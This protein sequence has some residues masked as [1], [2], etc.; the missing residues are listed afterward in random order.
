M[1]GHWRYTYVSTLFASSVFLSCS[2]FWGQFPGLSLHERGENAP[3]LFLTLEKERVGISFTFPLSPFPGFYFYF[4]VSLSFHNNVTSLTLTPYFNR[5]DANHGTCVD[6][7]FL[8]Q[9]P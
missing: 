6:V 8:N 7:D 2:V 3:R 9:H 1:Y 4:F 5:S